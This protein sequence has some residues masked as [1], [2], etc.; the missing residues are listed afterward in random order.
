MKYVKTSSDVTL[1]Y[2]FIVDSEFVI[3]DF[4]TIFYTLYDN[5]GL[6]VPGYINVQPDGSP[7]EDTGISIIIESDGNLKTHDYE[8]RTLTISFKYNNK[9]YTIEDSYQ[10]VD[11]ITFPITKDSIRSII[12][13]S[14]SEW[15]DDDID[16]IGSANDLQISTN[17]NIDQ[18]LS[19]GG[20]NTRS[21]LQ[22]IRL[23]TVFNILPTI[24]LI[25][26]QS[27]QADNTV[28]KR[29]NNIDF[30]ALRARLQAEY[31]GLLEDF[32]GAVP[33]SVVSFIVF[34]DTDPVTGE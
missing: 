17:I 24:E 27:E 7:V 18:I 3:P 10:I 9:P 33:Y 12:G 20:S 13:L 22:L 19:T 2:D 31:D 11:R 32:E 29:F 23:R 5:E 34:T 21:L 25:A 28:A 26:L 15:S 14:S 30:D 4:N 16:I 8:L 1:Y 6:P